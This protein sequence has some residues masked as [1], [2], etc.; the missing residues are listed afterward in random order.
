MIGISAIW[1]V[2][3]FISQH[4]WCD[5][6]CTHGFKLSEGGVEVSYHA[7]SLPHNIHMISWPTVSVHYS[8]HRNGWSAVENWKVSWHFR[9][10]LIG[11]TGCNINLKL[12]HQNQRVWVL[13]IERE[14]KPAPLNTTAFRN[15]WHSGG[16]GGKRFFQLFEAYIKWQ[17][18]ETKQPGIKDDGFI[19]LPLCGQKEDEN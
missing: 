1:V 16:T 2:W 4:L 7:V 18:Y 8:G 14:D 12:K 10:F 19:R 5:Y 17:R 9:L 13:T 6:F 15:H 11:G 3:L